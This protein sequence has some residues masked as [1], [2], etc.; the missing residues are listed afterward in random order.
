M[1]IPDLDGDPH[2]DEDDDFQRQVAAPPKARSN[3]V[4]SIR[5]LDS[6]VQFNLPQSKDNEIDLSLLIGALCP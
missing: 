1:D 5:E 4:Q 2:M 3:R 6:T